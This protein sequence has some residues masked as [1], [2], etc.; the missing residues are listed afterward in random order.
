MTAGGADEGRLALATSTVHCAAARAGLGGVGWIDLLQVERFIGKHRFDLVPSDIQYGAVQSTLLGYAFQLSPLG[1]V[2]GA[3]PLNDH[4]AVLSGDVGRGFM[5]PMLADTSLLGLYIGR[6]LDRLAVAVAAPL[7]AGR[8][9]LQ[10]LMLL[11]QPVDAFGQRVACAI[12]QHERDNHSPVDTDGTA[13]IFNVTVDQTADTDLPSEFCA[14]HGRFADAAFKRTG[15]AEFDP[16]K[17][18]QLHAGPFGV[19]LLDANIA[20]HEAEAVTDAGFLELREAALTLEE[21]TESRI[22]IL[23][24][25]LLAFLTDRFHKIIFSAQVFKLPRLGDEIQV[26]ACR[27]LILPIVVDPLV[28]AQVPDKA[29]HTSKFQHRLM[30]FTRGFQSVCEAAKNHI[31]LCKGCEC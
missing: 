19:Q 9:A 1:H 15:A 2:L 14:G 4:R 31:K 29:T 22:Q 16:T 28:K 17:F 8:D 18:G 11:I 13:D 12:G 20:T 6:T 21:P 5:R 25:A 24:R 23:H 7:A 10:S 27:A 30:L 26:V 3:Q